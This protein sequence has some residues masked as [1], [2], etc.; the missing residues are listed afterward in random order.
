MNDFHTP[1]LLAESL[2]GLN[3]KPNGVYVDATFGGGGH[4]SAIMDKL[5]DGYLI[6][7]DQDQAAVENTIKS[8]LRFKMI[9]DNFR[10]LKEQL[11]LI[12][13][14]K[15]DGLIADLGVSSYQFTD[16]KRGFSI[17]Y[18]A[19]IDMR[20]D[21]TI[22]KDGVFVLNNYN[23]ENLTR[24]LKDHS[25]FKSPK[26]IV[27]SIIKHRE[28]KTIRTTFDL[29]N[30]FINRVPKAQENKFF[31]RLFQ[32][33]RIEVNDEINALKDLLSQSLQL[34]RPQGRLVIISYHSVED[35]IVKSFMKFGNFSN[36]LKTD[37]FGN[38]KR[39]F[40]LIAKKPIA[41]SLL[42]IKANNKSRSAKLRICEK[43]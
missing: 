39:P 20:M 19:N 26:F 14:F 34:L 32:A 33:V 18:D 42:E 12:N 25:D 36:T 11:S 31:A 38:Q 41:P 29:K 22:K 10:N 5:I 2:N 3:V 24:I 43:I 1:V 28:K 16:N 6:V 13:I 15:I 35:K 7:F 30:I 17:K 40:K 23:R 37:F 9:C 4:S 8:D 21:E 27:D